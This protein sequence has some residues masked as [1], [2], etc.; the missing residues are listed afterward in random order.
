MTKREPTTT[1][2]IGPA[3]LICG[4]AKALLVAGR[5]SGKALP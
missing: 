5:L 4:E 2:T 3:R 1:V